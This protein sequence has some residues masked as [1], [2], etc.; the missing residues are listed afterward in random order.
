MIAEV[1]KDTVLDLSPND[2]IQRAMDVL[3][4]EEIAEVIITE[5]GR[6]LYMLREL[7]IISGIGETL[8]TVSAE[9]EGHFV[10]QDDHILKA[11]KKTQD[12]DL[13]IIPVVDREMKYLGA[14]R[15]EEILDYLSD[16]YSISEKESVIIIEHLARDYSLANISSIIE[17]EGGK[18][19]GVLMSPTENQ[20][21]RL[22]I[23]LTIHTNSLQHI[24]SSLERHEYEIVAQ[25]S[26]EE[27]ETIVKERY[28][29][30]M[31]FLNV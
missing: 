13:S 15:K 24:I 17:Q 10:Y 16:S 7:D 19:L 20:N 6:Y 29:S 31:N 2:D 21:E 25:M 3:S 4:Q 1:L 5:E 26:D 30:L 11:F 18:I 14:I 8:N 12:N 27:N 9:R 22:W 23:S 28:E